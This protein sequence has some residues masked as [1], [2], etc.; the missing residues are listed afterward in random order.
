MNFCK[1]CLWFWSVQNSHSKYYWTLPPIECADEC[2]V[3]FW[4]R[5][6]DGHIEIH[7]DWKKLRCPVVK[8]LNSILPCRCIMLSQEKQP[9]Q[10]GLQ[11]DSLRP[12]AFDIPLK[13]PLV[14]SAFPVIFKSKLGWKEVVLH[15]VK[16]ETAG[17]KSMALLWWRSRSWKQTDLC[18]ISLH[19]SAP[20]SV[21]F[22]TIAEDKEKTT[23]SSIEHECSNVQREHCNERCQETKP[24]WPRMMSHYVLFLLKGTIKN[25]QNVWK[26]ELDVLLEWLVSA[27]WELI[28]IW[29]RQCSDTSHSQCFNLH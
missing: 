13:L 3:L 22:N 4:T 26:W 29:C 10:N 25:E 18:L 21:G 8:L 28:C 15:L 24:K 16:C 2:R 9:S 12:A 23:S 20:C 5:A 27:S 1:A 7:Q 6:V 19:A 14:H 17:S 11:G